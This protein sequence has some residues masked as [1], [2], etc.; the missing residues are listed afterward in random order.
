MIV[1][2]VTVRSVSRLSPA[3]VRVELG[4]PELA[5]FGVDGSPLYDQR[6]KLLFPG[7][8]GRV[9]ALSGPSWYH[10]WALLPE[11]ER[12][13]LRTYTVRAVRGSGAETRVVVDLVLHLADGATGPGSRWASRA[14]VGDR[15][16]L[17][18]PRRGVPFGGIEFAP[19]DAGRLLLAADET[20]VPAVASILESLP[21]DSACTAYLEVP[22]TADVLSLSAPPGVRVVWLPRS[23]SAYGERLCRA[24]LTLFGLPCEPRDVELEVDPDLWETPSYSSSGEPVPGPAETGLDLYAWVAG[25]AGMVTRLRRHL[26]RDAGLDRRQVAFMGYWRQGVAMRG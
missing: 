26:V 14:G 21:V 25:E 22:T 5:G 11:E 20:A 6:V 8:S 16:V 19:G 15:L 24:V 17:V 2:E 9:P 18:G 13:H 7:P 4:G 3:F 1:A 23:G 10:D 12:G